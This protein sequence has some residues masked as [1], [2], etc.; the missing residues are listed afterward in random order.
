MVLT[1]TQRQDILDSIDF[2]L[3]ADYSDGN[4]FEI[5]LMDSILI[6]FDS[7]DC[8]NINFTFSKDGKRVSLTIDET[9]SREAIF[10][11]ILERMG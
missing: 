3:T 2:A 11:E 9:M 8:V 5:D 10:E 1:D 7:E 4:S 6:E